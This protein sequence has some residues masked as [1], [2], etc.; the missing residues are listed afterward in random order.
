[1]IVTGGGY[2]ALMVSP[3]LTGTGQVLDFFC[4]LS[5]N[6]TSF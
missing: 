5:R 6:P 2:I 4:D 3:D 1:M